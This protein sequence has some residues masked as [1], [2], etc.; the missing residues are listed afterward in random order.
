MA[1]T[2]RAARRMAE[3]TCFDDASTMHS[4]LGLRGDDD[5]NNNVILTDDFLIIDESSMIDMWLA[6]NLL[7]LTGTLKSIQVQIIF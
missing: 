3:S 1:P 5:F 6:H 4:A 2:G 7:I